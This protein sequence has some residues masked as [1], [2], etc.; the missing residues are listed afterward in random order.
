MLSPQALDRVSNAYRCG[1]LAGF[2]GEEESVSANDTFAGFDYREG[3]KAGK[4][5][6][7]WGSLSP[8]ERRAEH[9]RRVAARKGT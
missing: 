9:Q 1:Y 5:D 8:E 6:R 2:A 7:F 4:N 3:Y